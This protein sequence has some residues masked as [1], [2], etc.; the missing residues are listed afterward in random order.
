MSA[1]H[2]AGGG[3]APRPSYDAAIAPDGGSL[4]YIVVDDGY[5]R[6]VQ[7]PLQVSGTAVALGK[8]RDV[9]LPV[10]GPITK[11]V[12]SPDGRWLACQV[13]PHA[14]VRA[15]VW[16]VTT[17]PA[18][19]RAL[20]IDGGEG[21]SRELVGWDGARVAVTVEGEDGYG[22]SRLIDPVEGHVQVVDRRADARLI[23]AW[24]GHALVR[25]G[26]RT[27]RHLLLLRGGPASGGVAS[28]GLPSD[29][30]PSS[31]TEGHEVRL[32]D[33]DPG[34]LTDPGVILDD[35][36]PRRTPDGRTWPP[37]SGAAVRAGVLDGYVRVIV[38]TDTGADRL[39]LDQL[40]IT[41]SGAWRRVLA[42]RADAD[43][44]EFA[45]SADGSRA[46]LLWNVAG[47]ASCLQVLELLDGTLHDPITLPAAVASGL[48]LRADGRVLALTV[49]GPGRHRGVALTSLTA[50]GPGGAPDADDDARRWTLIDPVPALPDTVYP[51][52]ETL[53]A[54]DGLEL[55]GWL[56]RAPGADGPGPVLVYFHGGPEA[57]ARPEFSDVFG[58]LLA[59]GVSV[60]A[61]NV[62][63]SAGS[64]RAFWHADDHAR[65]WD[66]IRDAVDVIDH[67]L[68]RGIAAPGQVAVAGRSYGGYLTNALLAFHPGHAVC[69]VAICG[70]SDLH[71]FH[72]ETEPWIGRASYSKYGHPERDAQLL[73]DL[74]PIHRAADVRVPMLFIHGA[75]DTNVP[76]GESP[77][78]AAALR[79]AGSHAETLIVPGE[80]HDFTRPD[81]RAL[82]A[83]RLADFVTAHLPPP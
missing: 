2:P 43:L 76:V 48:S 33:P 29:G 15:Q 3:S 45:V 4:A 21:G 64:G 56:Y 37:A 40:T 19:P 80:G 31:S 27:D 24:D 77:R 12:Y 5:P 54:H 67:L 42:A 39:R 70:M 66:G 6:A 50:W 34:S 8:A 1:A 57:Q 61:P 82:L 72:R 53:R 69:G 13:S 74:S 25:V 59:R 71:A 51:V 38:R 23:D 36:R 14:G 55:S 20:W 81:H 49:E 18:D 78:M 83:T 17:D 11:V 65:R 10:E 63:G 60:F 68:A 47:G 7:R 46:A 41:P 32:G 52:G 79:H 30:L 16:A 9:R 28:D 35:H 44:D 22:E 75:N 73:T 26:P 62:R 58:P